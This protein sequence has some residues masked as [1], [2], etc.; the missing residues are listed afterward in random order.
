M[1]QTISTTKRHSRLSYT[2][3]RGNPILRYLNVADLSKILASTVSAIGTTL[4]LRRMVSVYSVQYR[5]GRFSSTGTRAGRA[6]RYYKFL[7]IT[8]VTAH[9][10]FS[11]YA[12]RKVWFTYNWI[13]ARRSIAR[14]MIRRA[15]RKPWIFPEHKGAMLSMET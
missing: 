10:H 1:K 14:V 2:E 6:P 13:A 8:Y 5:T 9:Y 12:N 3:L 15:I 4:Q 7:P 11:V